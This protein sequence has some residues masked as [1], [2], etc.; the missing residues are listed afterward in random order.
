MEVLAKQE[1]NVLVEKVWGKRVQ[2]LTV[3]KVHVGLIV[4]VTEFLDLPHEKWQLL[5]K[6]DVTGAK[7][8]V[9]VQD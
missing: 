5:L 9:Q 3:L 4:W 1:K 7:L 6:V 8:D 2:T